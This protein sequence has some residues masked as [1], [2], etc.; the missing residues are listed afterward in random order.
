[1]NTDLKYYIALAHIEGIGPILA[2]NL[3]SYCS[4]VKNIFEAKKGQLS[5]IPGIGSA[6]LNN[7]ITHKKA[8]LTFADKELKFMEQNEIEAIT[9]QDANYPYRLKQCAD[10]PIVLFKQG[11]AELNVSK[12]VSI[13]G[14]RRNSDYGK[15]IVRKF[16][17]ELKKNNITV[18]SGL[19]YGID[20]FAHK[21]S[22]D[23]NLTNIAVLAHGLDMIYPALHKNL[24][25][26]IMKNGALVTEFPSKTIPNRENFP[27]RN[28]I[29]AGL[30]DATIVV[31]STLK[32]G[33]VITAYLARDY[34]RDVF[35]FP[36]R[37]NDNA[38]NGCNNLIKKNIAGLIENIDDLLYQLGWQKENNS[39]KSM[40]RQTTLMLNLTKEEETIVSILKTEQKGISVDK[41]SLAS[42][43]SLSNIAG[44][45]LG[46]EMKNIV[47]VLPGNK[48][49]L[50]S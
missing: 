34:N 28:R 4:G 48:Y 13:V 25:H 12:I 49:K 3:I 18:V 35:A 39:K 47:E 32:G 9:F 31:E 23:N 33:A 36:G 45:L 38:S 16:V 40:S 6:T 46:L 20:F 11:N 8:A 2:K 37:I 21:N 42:K 7:I 22:V 29:V 41:I 1:M 10:S 19:A 5:K 17:E 24:S 44:T 30:C 26:Q 43:K 27:K 14:T 15:N 50:L